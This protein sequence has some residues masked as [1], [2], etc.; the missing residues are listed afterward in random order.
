MAI[1]T[2]P[3]INASTTIPPRHG[4]C[5]SCAQP[6]VNDVATTNARET[7]PRAFVVS[8]GREKGTMN[9]RDRTTARAQTSIGG[10]RMVIHA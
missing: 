5:F 4:G 3:H 10:D 1:V 2:H 8:L 6:N 9:M 7:C